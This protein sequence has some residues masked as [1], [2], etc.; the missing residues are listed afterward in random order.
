MKGTSRRKY[1]QKVSAKPTKTEL[2]PMQPLSTATRSTSTSTCLKDITL[3]CRTSTY[4]LSLEF[5]ICFPFPQNQGWK[6]DCRLRLILSP[7]RM[8][9]LCFTEVENMLFSPVTVT[10][11]QQPTSS[12]TSPTAA[13]SS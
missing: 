13:T 10:C 6:P 9:L 4:A 1:A 2:G 11:P 5:F 8:T 7:E 12:P 3:A